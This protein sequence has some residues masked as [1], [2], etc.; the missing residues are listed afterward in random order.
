M[1]QALA[2]KSRPITAALV[3]VIQKSQLVIQNRALQGIH[4]IVETYLS[5]LVFGNPA[6]ITETTEACGEFRVISSYHASIAEC[7]QVLSRVEAETG[8]SAERADSLTRKPSSVRLSGILNERDSLFRTDFLQ[9]RH[10]EGLAVE[11]NC[12]HGA[13]SFAD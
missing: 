9:L 8:R 11:M 6:M 4:A 13:A 7:A 5:M 1:S 3:R 12:D 2:I 10:A